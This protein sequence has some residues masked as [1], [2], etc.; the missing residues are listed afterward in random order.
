MR[1]GYGI[2]Y[3]A[4]LELSPFRG[5]VDFLV[6]VPGS[7]QLGDYHYEVWDT[8]LSLKVKP[9]AVVQLCCY[10]DMLTRLQGVQPHHLIVLLVDWWLHLTKCQQTLNC[11]TAALL[12]LIF[13]DGITHQL[14]QI[15]AFVFNNG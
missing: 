2:I 14:G 12:A 13:L 3:Q 11:L 4:A 8:K 7:S 10:T 5:Y 1:A 15:R 6:K 9:A